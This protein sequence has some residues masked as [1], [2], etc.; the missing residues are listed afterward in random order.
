M[1]FKEKLKDFVK[2]YHYTKEETDELISEAI[3]EIEEDMLE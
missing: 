1:S 2:K 3:Q